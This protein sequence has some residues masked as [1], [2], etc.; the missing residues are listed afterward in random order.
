MKE[1]YLI[2]EE[3]K[4]YIVTDGCSCE[5]V[6]YVLTKAQ[7]KA[8]ETILKRFNID[9]QIEDITYEEIKGY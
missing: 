9:V 4:Y 5:R 2:M 8:I 7:A 1:R 6:G 3:K